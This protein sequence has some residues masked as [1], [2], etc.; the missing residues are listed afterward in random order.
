M[1]LNKTTIAEEFNKFL[2]SIIDLPKSEE[3]LI[4]ASFS[5]E[6]SSIEIIKLITSNLVKNNDF[7][8]WKITNEKLEFLACCPLLSFNEFGEERLTKTHNKIHSIEKTFKSNWNDNNLTDIPLVVG[9]MKFSPDQ[10]SKIWEDFS[11]SDWFIPKF[12]F[13]NQK[14][15]THLIYNSTIS[16]NH[17]NDL[18]KFSNLLEDL[19][20]LSF[21]EKS[22]NGIINSLYPIATNS[23]T[24]WANIVN[25]ALKKISNGLLTKVVL[26]RE[27]RYKLQNEANIENYLSFLAEKYPKCYTFAFRRNKSTFFGASPEKL[28][29]IS[30]GWIEVDALAGSAPRGKDKIEDVEM[31]NFLLHS[32]KNLFEQ[33][34]VVYFIHNLLMKI[35]DDIIFEDEPIIRKLPNIQHLW[36]IIRAKLKRD[37]KLFDV[38]MRLHP[39]P[40]ICG[41]PWKIA[42]NFILEMEPHD[43]GLYSGNIGWFNFNGSGEFAVGIRSAIIKEDMLHAY[44]GCGI[45]EGSEAKAEYEESEIK[46]KPI[47]SLFV[48]EKVYQP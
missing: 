39:T 35:S 24:S 6:I 27:V 9:G 4:V 26:S 10:T 22:E 1:H 16:E 30:K 11:D 23:Y 34:A 21:T 18:N 12:L 41:D 43:R 20:T 13:F 17:Q 7:F 28:A 46:L 45:V 40:A 31:E 8:Y 33:R 32:E 25:K 2:N 3:N 48:N 15:K 47:L 44:A 42:K 19:E 29:R 37:T 36:T 14:N 38:L 5:F